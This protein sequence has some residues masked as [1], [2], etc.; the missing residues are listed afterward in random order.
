MKKVDMTTRAFREHVA[1]CLI[2][3]KIKDTTDFRGAELCDVGCALAAELCDGITKDEKY[4]RLL[5]KI[6]ERNWRRRGAD[7]CSGGSSCPVRAL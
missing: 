7:G 5:R 2:C 1:N 4:M 6:C 3:A